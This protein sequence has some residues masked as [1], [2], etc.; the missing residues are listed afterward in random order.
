MIFYDSDLEKASRVMLGAAAD[1]RRV[2]QEPE[3]SCVVTGFGDNGLNLELRVWIRD[4]QNGIGPVKNELLRGVLRRFKEE[5]I[6]LPYP[7]M[8]TISPCPE[9]RI[10]TEPRSEKAS[11]SLGLE[12]PEMV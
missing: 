1:T 3:A 5:G 7:Q 11:D 2:L 9:V 6:E 4:P 12:F 10:R 8:G